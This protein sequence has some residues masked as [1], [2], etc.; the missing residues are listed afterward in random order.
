[1]SFKTS[2][3]SLYP[4]K[5]WSFLFLLSFFC[6]LF[7]ETSRSLEGSEQPVF[8]RS[9]DSQEVTQLWLYQEPESRNEEDPPEHTHLHSEKHHKRKEGP[10]IVSIPEEKILEKILIVKQGEDWISETHHQALCNTS[11]RDLFRILFPEGSSF[12]GEVRT[13]DAGLH[14][15]FELESSE[16]LHLILKNRQGEQL[17]HIL[18]GKEDARLHRTFLRE[19]ST[20]RESEQNRV[21]LAGPSLRNFFELSQSHT[22]IPPKT[23]VDLTLLSPDFLE[24]NQ[25]QIS[26]VILSTPLSHYEMVLKTYFP[27]QVRNNQIVSEEWLLKSPVSATLNESFESILKILSNLTAEDVADSPYDLKKYQLDS[28]PFIANIS[29]SGPKEHSVR[30]GYNLYQGKWLGCYGERKCVY[31]F[32]DFDG[33]SLFGSFGDFVDFHSFGFSSNAIRIEARREQD[34]YVLEKVGPSWTLLEPPLPFPLYPGKVEEILS[35]L[36]DLRPANIVTKM[37]VEN[38]FPSPEKDFAHIQLSLVNRVESLRIGDVSSA[39]SGERLVW[40]PQRKGLFTAKIQD[41]SA[42]VPPLSTLLDWTLFQ[43]DPNL[44]VSIL[45]E[46][47]GKMEVLEKAEEGWRNKTAPEK[48][49]E[50]EKLQRFLETF[51]SLKAQGLLSQ[52]IDPATEKTRLVLSYSNQ[53]NGVFWVGSLQNSARYFLQIENSAWTFEISES[54]AKTLLSLRME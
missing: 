29:Y 16:A 53:K 46:F 37:T 5:R 43:N 2:I 11:V 4:Y 3:R 49:V 41:L 25:L 6:Y 42:V 10:A 28:P 30:I 9:F 24:K 54:L 8:W 1:M 40:T 13:L 44:A 45:C 50:P 7:L 15:I 22:P 27:P 35:S 38:A 12:L 21:V 48:K 32:S 26:Q 20:G 34:S 39:N 36:A 51:R 52:P 47:Q 18:I 31:Q 23:F 17:A 19:I 33:Q 14:P